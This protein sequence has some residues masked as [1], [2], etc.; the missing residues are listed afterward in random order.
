M[1]NSTVV[2]LGTVEEVTNLFSYR[3][4]TG[5]ELEDWVGHWLN[6]TVLRDGFAGAWTDVGTSK[7]GLVR[8]KLTAPLPDEDV[9][10]Y[11]ARIEGFLGAGRLAWKTYLANQAAIEKAGFRFLL[12]Q[13]LALARFRSI[14]L[15]HFPP[16]ETFSYV[17]YLYSPT[18]RRW[19][20]L[21][22][23]QRYPAADLSLAE[24]IVDAVPLAAPGGASKEIA[25]FDETFR[26]YGKAM[27]AAMLAGDGASTVPVVAY[28]SP[29][30]TW[31]ADAYPDQ[32]KGQKLDVLTLV[33]LRLTASEAK[34]PV[35][36]ANHPSEF[37]YFSDN[38]PAQ[39]RE[40]MR[41]DLIAARWQATMATRADH[42]PAGALRDAKRYW[43]S[44]PEAIEAIV[45][46]QELEFGYLE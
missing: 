12:P 39:N 13:G 14:Q 25:P 36:C 18:N 16:L 33:S 44:R 35:L 11:G 15:L 9:S 4:D 22:L 27:L 46:T 42:D 19:E 17:D 45:K 34:T 10:A 3:A 32:L 28:G 30:R 26:D 21:L 40:I 5:V 31:L 29:V 7:D 37:L 6:Q 23:Y 1:T 8:A 43:D 38:T 41:Q 20:S 24:R 2:P